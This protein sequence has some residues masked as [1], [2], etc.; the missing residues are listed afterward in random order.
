MEI[1][2]HFRPDLEVRELKD[3]REGRKILSV[4]N[5]GFVLEKMGKYV[6]STFA[7]EKYFG[8]NEKTKYENAILIE[9]A[10][11]ALQ[12]Y[13]RHNLSNSSFTLDELT[14][15]RAFLTNEHIKK[16]VDELFCKSN[17]TGIATYI[18]RPKHIWGEWDLYTFN[19]TKLKNL[20]DSDPL[21]R[22]FD[23][24]YRIAEGASKSS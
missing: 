2:K 12:L 10:F 24:A 23:F 3:Y 21:S 5:T 19:G 18:P 1:F 14:P 4:G 16:F 7:R 11:R 15:F 20:P 9:A 22:R 17:V 13:L 8:H 6:E